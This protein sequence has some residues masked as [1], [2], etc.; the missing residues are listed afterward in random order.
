MHNETVTDLNPAQQ[1]VIDLLGRN[2]TRAEF[3]DGLAKELLGVL[4]EAVAPLTDLVGDDPLWISKRALSNLH[5]CEMHHVATD[6]TFEWTVPM[7]R[8]TI[9]HKAVELSVHWNGE[10]APRTLVDESIARLANGDRSIAKFLQSRSEADQAQLRSDATGM[11]AAFQ[12]CFPPLKAEWRPVMESTS[13]VELLNGKIV[14]SGK[15][16]LTL[17]RAGNKVIIDMKTG[18]PNLHHRDDL[19]FYALLETLKLGVPPRK[20]ASY[21]LDSA[22][23][24]P[25]DVTVDL[26]D[27]ALR[28]TVDG[29]VKAIELRAGRPPLVVPGPTCRWCPVQENCPTGVA[30]LTSDKDDS[31]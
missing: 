23:A 1:Q 16:D 12:E 14:L 5:G 9:A 25:E 29:V 3:P 2:G 10:A 27:A 13:R 15:V 24:Q 17:G 6:A 11:V 30:Y 4:E 22:R 26:L 21:Y 20:L 7:A 19:R 8:G 28:R 18:R 31:Y